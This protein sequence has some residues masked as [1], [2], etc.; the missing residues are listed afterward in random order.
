MGGPQSAEFV[1]GSVA[2]GQAVGAGAT[3]DDLVVWGPEH[4]FVASSGDLGVTIG[5]I[6]IGKKSAPDVQRQRVPFFTIWRR[7]G[8]GAPWRYIAE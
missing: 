1:R 8:P 4:V 7:D 5:T 2:I 3:P 6:E